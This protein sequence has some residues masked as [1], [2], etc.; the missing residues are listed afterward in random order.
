MSRIV[1]LLVS[2]QSRLDGRPSASVPEL[3]DETVEQIEIRAGLGV[4]GDRYFNRR[5]HRDGSVT[6]MAAEALAPWGVGL[7]ATR[8]NVLLEGVDVDSAPSRTLRLDSGAGAVVLR[9]HRRANPCAWLDHTV[10]P[11]AWK[12]LRG[13]GGMRCEPLTDGVLRVGPVEVTWLE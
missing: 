2:A 6:I 1:E 11:G 8:R 7:A 10:G 13:H 3:P 9:L 4:V 12:G 5:A